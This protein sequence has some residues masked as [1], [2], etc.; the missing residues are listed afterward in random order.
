MT[1]V[2]FPSLQQPWLRSWDD[3]RRIKV[4][5]QLLDLF[6]WRIPTAR[7]LQLIPDKFLHG[8][9]KLEVFSTLVPHVSDVI[10]HWL[11]TFSVGS[12]HLTQRG[13]LWKTISG[14]FPPQRK[15]LEMDYPKLSSRNS[16]K[17]LR[18]THLE[19]LWN[20]ATCYKPP[21]WQTVEN[22]WANI[23]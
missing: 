22:D 16:S 17:K 15:M 7:L 1:A 11:H 20:S 12:D 9:N 14:L 6:A 23:T 5:M 2:R 19:L 4:G 13:P 8:G 18:P 3:G 10:S 21:C